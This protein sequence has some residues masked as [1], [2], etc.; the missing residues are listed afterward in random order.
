MYAS[1]GYNADGRGRQ[2]GQVFECE[3]VE[4]YRERYTRSSTATRSSRPPHALVPWIIT[5]DDHEA[6]ND[7][8]DDVSG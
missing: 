6:A 8:M 3:M 2:I 7:N 1:G 4:Q 5:W